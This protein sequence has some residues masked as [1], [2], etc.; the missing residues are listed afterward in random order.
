[1]AKFIISGFADEAASELKGQIAALKRNNMGYIEVR[2]I[3]GKCIIDYSEDELKAIRDELNNSGIKVSSIGSPIGKYNI[4]DDFEPHFERLKKAVK[5]AQILEAKYIRMFSFFIPDGEKARD[6][7]EEVIKR[8]NTMVEYAEKEGVQLC[9][10]NEARIYGC[11]PEEVKDILESV[12]GIRGIFD[13]ANY[14]MDDADITWAVD[15]T[16]QYIEYLHIKDACLDGHIIVPAGFGDGKVSEVIEKIS[17]VKD[18]ETFVSIEPHLFSFTGYSNID[19]RELKHKFHF[20]NQ[21]ESFDA[22]V[23]ALKDILK[24][25]GY[26]EGEDKIW[27]K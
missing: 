18:D 22:A 3:G 8:L 11:L 16:K 17:N 20:E 12:K 24:N 15:N 25:L 7:R 1:M 4:V 10:E 14:I 5:T 21:N 9:H 27:K 13:P 19:N 2:N 6:Y 26:V 23:N